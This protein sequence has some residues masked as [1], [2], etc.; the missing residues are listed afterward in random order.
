MEFGYKI[1]RSVRAQVFKTIK[2][3]YPIL[4]NGIR[5][6]MS[7]EPVKKSRIILGRNAVCGDYV[8]LGELSTKNKDLP[9]LR[10][11]S[12]ARIRSHTVIY[13]GNVIGDGFQTGH[14]VLIREK[15]RIGDNVSVGSFSDIGI[16]NEIG[17]DVRIH[18]SCFIPEFVVIKDGA[19]LGP[20]VTIL[21]IL[22]P[23]CPKFTECAKGIVIR[24]GAKIGG[25]VTIGP[26][27]E[28]GK[29]ALV[30][31]GSVVMKSI[32]DG[33]VAYGNPAKIAQKVRDMKCKMGYYDFP[34][35]WQ[36]I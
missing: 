18:S 34:Y 8:V 26:G 21:N 12:N 33:S 35:Q 27:V 20:R 9:P 31:S 22:H 16:E 15:N 13:S 17:S 24:E 25:N 23:P 6:Y 4:V 11:G 1:V 29:N 14:H 19:W 5:G 3:P 28:I 10:I 7:T 2:I 30:G 36:K 32:P